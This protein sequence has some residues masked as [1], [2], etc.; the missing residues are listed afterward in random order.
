LPSRR[1]QTVYTGSDPALHKRRPT[2]EKLMNARAWLTDER[3]RIDAGNWIAPSRRKPA[4]QAET[5]GAFARAWLA[6]RPLKR[7]SRH[8][9]GRILKKK[10]LPALGEVPLKDIT[11]LTVPAPFSE[12]PV[13]RILCAWLTHMDDQVTELTQSGG[14]I[15][16]K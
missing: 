8:L 2:F 7:C 1:N 11:P 14:G 12:A 15:T 13:S 16:A 9:Y 5:L 4:R 6:A 10:I 3:R